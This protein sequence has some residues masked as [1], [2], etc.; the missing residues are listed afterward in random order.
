[1]KIE[2]NEEKN[3][4]LKEMR[5]INFDDALKAMNNWGL[6]G[7]ADNENYQNQKK[8]ILKINNYVYVCPFIE[9]GN[10]LFL[11][12]LYPSRKYSKVYNS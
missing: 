10:G 3:K 9:S 5:W 8:F 4:W 1:M 11:K 2:F 12:T 6:I 7:V